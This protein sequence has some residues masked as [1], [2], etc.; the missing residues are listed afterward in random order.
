[1]QG[2]EA[3]A[4]QQLQQYQQRLQQQAHQQQ[5]QQQMLQRQQQLQKQQQQKQQQLYQQQLHQQHMHPQQLQQQGE[6]NQRVPQQPQ[7]ARFLQ[8]TPKYAQP[9]P[10]PAGRASQVQMPRFSL[11]QLQAMQ[12]QW[13]VMQH[14]QAAPQE[15]RDAQR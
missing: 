6:Q 3:Q 15:A 7:G 11:Q 13:P 9:K 5:L 2:T 14:L 8:P 12:V 4:Q 1:M 10:P